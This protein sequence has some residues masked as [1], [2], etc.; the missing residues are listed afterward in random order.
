MMIWAGSDGVYEYDAHHFRNI[1]EWRAPLNPNDP[2]TD[3]TVIRE[4][5]RL[6]DDL[7]VYAFDTPDNQRFIMHRND[8][9]VKDATLP[10][11]LE[12][13]MPKVASA[14]VAIDTA[15]SL[16]DYVNRFK[17]P[18]TV[19]FASEQDN[20]IVAVIDY[21]KAADSA[22]TVAAR[23]SNQIA[24]LTLRYSDQWETWMGKD[25]TLMRHVEFATFLEE[26]Q[27]DV[28]RPSG[29]DLLEI[30]R[31]LQVRQ[32]VNFSSSI[33]MGDEVSITFQKEDDVS[34]KSQMSLPVSFETLIPVFFGE[35]SVRVLNW[36]RRKVTSGTLALGYKMSQRKAIEAQEFARIVS[37]IKAGVG[38]LTTIYGRRQA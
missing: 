10:N 25:E 4:L 20:K 2:Q 28:T 30:C 33:R 32:D 27:F 19:L 18:D 17:N 9:V 5:T 22:G 16:I 3:A 31:D 6:A 24:T 26:N 13:L 38:G 14:A 15:A 8:F 36:T 34:T 21:H 29:A 11:R 12:V 7:P 1:T 37:E 23:L 35:G